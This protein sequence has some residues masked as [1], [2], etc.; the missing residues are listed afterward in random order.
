MNTPSTAVLDISEE[1]PL[2]EDKREK[3]D[4]MTINAIATPDYPVSM[5]TSTLDEPAGEA[6]KLGIDM[7]VN[8]ANAK[9]LDAGIDLFALLTAEKRETRVSLHKV[10]QL[11]QGMIEREA[12]ATREALQSNPADVDELLRQ[13]LVVK[14]TTGK[15][16]DDCYK[17]L[18]HMLRGM[19]NASRY[20]MPL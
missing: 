6:E 19:R 8:V 1:P 9:N 2:T 12:R 13:L 14:I 18:K 16:S 10:I 7:R 11:K 20:K 15:I 17:K 5:V 4:D 3:T